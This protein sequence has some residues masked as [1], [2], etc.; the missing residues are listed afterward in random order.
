MSTVSHIFWFIVWIVILV[1]FGIWLSS[2]CAFL[3]IL[4]GIFAPCIPPLDP[5]KQ[6]F[7]KGVDF[8]NMCSFNAVE[9]KSLV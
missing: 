7:R 5:L 3:Y 8:A 1:L 2:I 4:V 9:G 6:T